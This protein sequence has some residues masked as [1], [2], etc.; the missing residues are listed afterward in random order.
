MY[1]YQVFPSVL[2]KLQ[3]HITPGGWMTRMLGICRG[4]GEER[5]RV[6]YSLILLRYTEPIAMADTSHVN[7]NVLDPSSTGE[8]QYRLRCYNPNQGAHGL[9]LVLSQH[10]I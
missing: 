1:T 3:G 9:L 2:A 7:L 4:R 8:S 10:E 6:V 5:N